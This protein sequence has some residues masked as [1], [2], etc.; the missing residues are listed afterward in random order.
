MAFKT[1]PMG[2]FLIIH[3]GE[4]YVVGLS[5]VRKLAQIGFARAASR[6]R[7]PVGHE[8]SRGKRDP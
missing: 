2:R 6:R 1:S 8:P 3:R 4:S 5:A 7:P